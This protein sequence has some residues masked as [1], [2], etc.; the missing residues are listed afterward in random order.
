[1][2]H[3]RQLLILTAALGWLPHLGIASAQQSD[4]RAIVD[5][6]GEVV[7]CLLK[8]EIQ[9]ADRCAGAGRLTIVQPIRNGNIRWRTASGT[10][11]LEN[12]TPQ[13]P[14]CALSRARWDPK[15]ERTTSAGKSIEAVD[16]VAVL[17][18]MS[19][20]PDVVHF[21]EQDV[22][23]FALDLDNDGEQE[24]VFIASNVRR[25]A[26]ANEKT[27]QPQQY[28]IMGG[29]LGKNAE[30]PSTFFF[31]RGEYIG[32]TD[33]IGRAAIV[34]VVSISPST[35]EI[36]LLVETGDKSQA[37]VRVRRGSLQRIET[38]SSRCD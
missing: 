4:L 29:V 9:F 23:A 16:P 10:V 15:A 34:G 14:D 19:K 21:A 24:I 20:H 1:M 27:G 6:R 17:L 25:V 13:N 33:A 37:L 2:K 7:L 5:H 36:A 32:A 12:E 28:A 18:Q 11:T 22:T 35:Q 31:G 8:G 30:Y 3:L 38:Y 26:E